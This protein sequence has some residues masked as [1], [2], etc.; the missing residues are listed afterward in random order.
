MTEVLGQVPAADLK[1][2]VVWLPILAHDDK[3]AATKNA[4]IFDDPRMT[5]YWDAVASQGTVWNRR[6]GLPPAQLAWTVF[7]VMPRD[8]TWEDAP[9]APAF[10]S[11]GLNI[12]MGVKYSAVAL[13][14]AVEE[15]LAGSSTPKGPVKK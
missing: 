13:R 11:H 6:L 12:E 1:V 4:G 5:H 10:W 7:I 3:Q 2:Y 14:Q 15:A 8:A 9:S